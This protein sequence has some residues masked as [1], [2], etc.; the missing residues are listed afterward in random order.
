MIKICWDGSS[1]DEIIKQLKLEEGRPNLQYYVVNY[2]SK[3][4]MIKLNQ[5]THVIKPNVEYLVDEKTLA[6]I[7]NTKVFTYAPKEDSFLS[8]EDYEYY[9]H[10][11]LLFDPEIKIISKYED[12]MTEISFIFSS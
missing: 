2:P 10:K 12:F 4:I 9:T 6:I 1:A 7:E 3:E 11:I 8:Q 5:E